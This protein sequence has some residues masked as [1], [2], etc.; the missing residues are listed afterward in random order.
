MHAESVKITGLVDQ[1]NVTHLHSSALKQHK[2]Y[3]QIITG[4]YSFDEDSQFAETITIESNLNE[5]STDAIMTTSTD[6]NIT[7]SHTFTA[8][9]ITITKPNLAL[10][11]FTINNV[12][13]DNIM[14][15]NGNQSITGIKSYSTVNF[16]D[17]NFVNSLQGI[18][19]IDDFIANKV[20]ETGDDVITGHVTFD[21][22]FDVGTDVNVG[23]LVDGVD[24]KALL[25][26]THQKDNNTLVNGKQEF[27]LIS[28]LCALLR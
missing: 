18:S 28:V 2:G 11:S 6:Q 5:H 24:V 27:F 26:S 21:K 7:A 12:S 22:G 17:M 16:N 20:S 1:V 4:K 15:I 9:V 3:E 23:G 13:F 25:E 8:D 10:N 14:T 19:S